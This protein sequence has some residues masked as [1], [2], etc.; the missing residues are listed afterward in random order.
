MKNMKL[1]G[2]A[3]CAGLAGTAFAQCPGAPAVVEDLGVLSAGLTNRSVALNGT[4]VVW[5]K[6]S[7]AAP[8][9]MSSLTFLSVN[10]EG[11]AAPITDTEIGIYDC[12][13][14]LL[15]ADDD[16]GTGNFSQL[17]FGSGDAIQNGTG[18]PWG[19]GR[20]GGLAA[21]DYYLAIGNFNINF[22]LTAWGAAAT[23]GTA[24]GNANLNLTLGSVSAIADPS[25]T[26]DLGSLSLGG[27]INRVADPLA[28][29]QVQWY[30]VSV[31]ESS[32]GLNQYLDIDTEGSV[33]AA[34]N[35]TRLAVY[36]TAGVIVGT[37]AP[38]TRLTF[39]TGLTDAT[40]GSGSLSQISL[41]VGNRPAVGTSL[42][43]NGRD[44]NLQAGTYLVGVAG[45]GTAPSATAA[46]GSNFGFVSTS[47]NSGTINFN[48]RAGFGAIPLAG[49]G[50][51]VPTSVN[52]CG[53]SSALLRVTVTPATSPSSTG[54]A[55][56][57]DLSGIG[58]ANP[59]TFFD[60]GSN[61]DVTAGDNI[62]SYSAAIANSVGAAAYTFPFTV[63]DAQAR[64]ANGTVPLTVTLCPPQGDECSNPLVATLGN[65]AFTTTGLANNATTTC[66][67]TGEDVFFVFTPA[68]TGAHVFS[69][70]GAGFDSVLALR[71][72][73]A[74]QIVCDDDGCGDGLT[75]SITSNLTAG[76]PVIVQIDGFGGADG[77][78]TLVISDSVPLG[79][80]GTAVT[81]QE[82][83]TVLLR[84]TVSPGNP[85]PST[86]VTV[87]GDLSSIGGSSTQAFF[88]DG[89]NGDVTG[90][91]NIFSYA[92]S[93]PISV[94]T[95]AYSVAVAA[96]DAQS[97]TANGTIAVTVTNGASGAC[98]TAG[99]CAL[100]RE[101][102]CAAG[103]GTWQGNGSSCGFSY[104]FASSSGT[105]EDISTTGVELTGISNA[106][107]ATTAQSLP[108][109][110]NHLGNAYTSVNV[111]SN[112]NLQFGASNSTVFTNV[113][114][115]NAAVPN[116][117]LAP[118]WDDYDL[119]EASAGQG[120][121]YYLDDSANGRV[122][123]SWQNVAQFNVVP[124][125]SNN[126]QV[127]LYSNGNAE[128]R[129]GAMNNI[130]NPSVAGDT[131]T[132]GYEDSAG[133]SG[134]SLD[135]VS[136]V[137]AGSVAF[138]LNAQNVNPCGPSCDTIDFNNDGLFPDTMDIDDFL[139]VFSGGPCSNDPNCGDI[140]Y[141]NDG[142]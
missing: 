94:Q 12:A 118:A 10:S 97:R 129:Y 82:M 105:F 58:L 14:N 17:S 60:D 31:P 45:P 39:T 54:I 109:T 4:G 26:I 89:T 67:G 132:I 66:G 62:F 15:A 111:S 142:L 13:G 74:T 101:T 96:A 68:I 116:D 37:L 127:I 56:T 55:V 128:F 78:G 112:G 80:A 44:G 88:D 135:P 87:T 92:Y 8:V 47:T 57:A 25:G 7:L 119:D 50:S 139:S 136:Q 40:D 125:D 104:T 84:A 137:G 43:Y 140:D 64:T 27:A 114:I 46:S 126:F 106:D 95:G 61:G 83:T 2:L 75:S 133:A 120:A 102:L 71:S 23:S 100:S 24:V 107:D 115:P 117:M 34:T 99:S 72:D 134:G 5:Y 63:T 108:F 70:C 28:A 59:Q 121:V 35:A 53:S 42:A 33:L 48:I 124:L 20:D 110:F 52:N 19:N 51:S 123:F 141:N 29:S 38:A 91:D 16:D 79:V 85:P 81:G 86:G 41:G 73:C 18:N 36:N 98:C 76:V 103:G 1:L 21:G 90:G 113:A 9:S 69:V 30:K 130:L 65:N 138:M 32:L 6:F 131:V 77:S 3:L 22:G 11:T 93:L 122:V 49:T